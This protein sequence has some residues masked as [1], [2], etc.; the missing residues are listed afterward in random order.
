MKLKNKLGYFIIGSAMV[1]A[2]V[3]IAT[4]IL[5]MNIPKREIILNILS[6]GFIAHLLFIWIPI[7]IIFRKNIKK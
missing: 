5:L 6:V 1:W 3:I 4:A 2:A 7:A